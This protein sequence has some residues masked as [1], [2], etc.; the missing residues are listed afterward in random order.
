MK[1][2]RGFPVPQECYWDA[3]ARRNWVIAQDLVADYPYRSPTGAAQAVLG[4]NIA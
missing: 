3:R 1:D 4:E 2:C